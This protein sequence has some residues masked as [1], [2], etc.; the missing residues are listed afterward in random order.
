MEFGFNMFLC[1]DA[2]LHRSALLCLAL[3]ITPFEAYSQW[4]GT[5]AHAR[6]DASVCGRKDS[7][8]NYRKSWKSERHPAGKTK[9]IRSAEK[10]R[11]LNYRVRRGDTLYSIARRYKTSVSEITRINNLK[12]KNSIRYGMT[13]KIPVKST[14]TTGKKTVTTESVSSS[15][16]SSGKPSF[17]WPVRKVVSCKRDGFDGVKSIGLIISAPAG[18]AVLSSAPGTVQ[19]V[20]YMRGYGNFVMVRHSNRYFTVYSRLEKITVQEGQ[21]V[22]AGSQLGRIDAEIKNIHFQIDREGKSV[23]PL[24]HLPKRS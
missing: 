24:S 8:E 5:V 17:S 1:R 13:L 11:I 6:G 14:G 15:E 16:S 23:N 2:T 21:H 9:T 3:I 7:Y 19:K 18:S 4:N 12:Q 10:N 20:G 22:A